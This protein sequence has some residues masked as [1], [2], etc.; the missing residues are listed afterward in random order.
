[1][2]KHNSSCTLGCLWEPT[3]TLY[4]ADGDFAICDLDLALE[5]RGR[6]IPAD[7]SVGTSEGVE[8]IELTGIPYFWDAAGLGRPL[9]ADLLPYLTR[10]FARPEV[11]ELAAEALLENFPEPHEDDRDD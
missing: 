2:T 9:P 6:F 1:M 5:L 4:T 11:Q 3:M 8:D 7:E 10:W